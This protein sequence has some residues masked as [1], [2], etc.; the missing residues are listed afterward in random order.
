MDYEYEGCHNS[1]ESKITTFL[2]K[3]TAHTKHPFD[4]PKIQQ[5]FQGSKCSISKD[6]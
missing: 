1:V 4:T 3:W 6:V 5:E 2:S